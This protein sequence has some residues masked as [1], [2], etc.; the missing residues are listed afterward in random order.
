MGLLGAGRGPSAFGLSPA[1]AQATESY[2][3]AI[4]MAEGFPSA[5][6]QL[7]TL[8][9]KSPRQFPTARTQ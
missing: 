8:H 5:R 6:N 4:L 3:G 2:D 7:K 1:L 9:T